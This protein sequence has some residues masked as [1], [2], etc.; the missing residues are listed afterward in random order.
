MLS[1]WKVNIGENHITEWGCRCLDALSGLVVVPADSQ[2]KSAQPNIWKH[3]CGYSSLFIFLDGGKGKC[4]LCPSSSY[5]PVMM[6]HSERKCIWAANQRSHI[7][8]FA[9]P[10]F[11]CNYIVNLCAKSADENCLITILALNYLVLAGGKW[12]CKIGIWLWF[13]FIIY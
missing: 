8:F 10:Q 11:F 5:G 2:A 6:Q 13:I 4:P 7:L 12:G 3:L 9:R 1:S